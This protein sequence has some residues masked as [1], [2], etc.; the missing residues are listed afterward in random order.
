MMLFSKAEVEK[1]LMVK[2]KIGNVP[3]VQ[4]DHVNFVDVPMPKGTVQHMVKSA[5]KF[6]ALC[7]SGTSD[8]CDSSHSRPKKGKG[9]GKKFHEVTENN[10]EMD[11]LAD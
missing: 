1:N 5:A 8:K 9:R 11:D 6:K 4:A 10:T 3:A 7:K 2:A